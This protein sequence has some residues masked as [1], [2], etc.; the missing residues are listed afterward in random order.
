MTEDDDEDKLGNI[1]RHINNVYDE[2]GHWLAR[3]QEAKHADDSCA[4]PERSYV[5]CATMER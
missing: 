3:L 4:R 1:S 2:T 5:A